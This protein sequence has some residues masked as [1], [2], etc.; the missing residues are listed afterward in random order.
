MDRES[1][2]PST[3]FKVAIGGPAGDA[4][5][6]RRPRPGRP[7]DRRRRRVRQGDGARTRRRHLGRPCRDR[8]AGLDQRPRA[9]LQ[10]AAGLPDGR[11]PDRPL[12]RLVADRRSH[13]RDPLRGQPRAGLRLHLHRRRPGAG[14][15]RPR[16]HR[17]LA[18]ADR[19]R[20]QR[21]GPRRGDADPRLGADRGR[22]RRRRDGSRT[23]RDPGR[24]Q[25]RAG[26][27]RVLPPLPLGLVPGRRR[28]PPLPR[29]ASSATAPTRSPRPRAP[30]RWSP[31]CSRATTAPSRSAT[32]RRST[33]CSPTAPCAASG[34]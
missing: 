25:R 19:V 26:A 29:P 5:D 32:T 22:Q 17:R 30:P 3:E 18:G 21:L 12:D 23:G 7:R 1:D 8:L 16:L 13:L 28:R 27:R 4:G 11:R 14:G 15:L 31:N 2:S 9:R 24:D 6:R 10:P 33:R 20:H 34:R